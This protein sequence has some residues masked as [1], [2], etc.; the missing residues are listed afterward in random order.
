MNITIG[1]LAKFDR[2]PYSRGRMKQ[3]GYNRV[4]YALDLLQPNGIKHRDIK[5]PSGGQRQHAYVAVTIAQDT[6]YILL[7]EP[8]DNLDMKH[9]VQV[10][11]TL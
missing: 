9:S 6:G 8:L 10:M 1:Q 5:T 3:E 4:E 2:F 11:Q 7:N